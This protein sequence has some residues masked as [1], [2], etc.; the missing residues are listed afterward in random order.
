[1]N[2]TNKMNETN[3][4]DRSGALL[5]DQSVR[6]NFYTQR[7]LCYT[8]DNDHSQTSKGGGVLMA[9]KKAAA[10]KPAKKAAKK[11]K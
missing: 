5:P 6:Q 2:Q 9:K 10:K 3:Q 8:R 4:P 11:K 1:M 7:N